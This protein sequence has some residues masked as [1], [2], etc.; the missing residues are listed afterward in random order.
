M[1]TLNFAQL[2]QLAANAG[3][4]SGLQNT[5]AAI[6]LAESGGN[7]Q[8]T[9]PNDNGGRQTSWGLWQISYGNHTPPPNWSNPQANA[10]LAYQKYLSQGLGA[11]GTYTS[12][13]YK[14][15]MN[16][17]TSSG[18]APWYTFPR[19]DN[20]GQIDPQ[21]NFWKPDSNIQLPGG[22]PIT[23]LLSGTVTSV[24]PTTNWGGQSVVTVKL[25]TPLNSLATHTFY[26]HMSG[27]APG[28]SVGQHVN[29]GDLIGYNN[30]SG[31]V[32]LGFGL[33]S[34]DVYGSG[35]AWQVLQQDLA[36]GGA[37]LLNPT[38][39]LNSA[40]QSGGTWSG[41]GV[42]S[43]N[44]SGL[45]T[46]TGC[47]WYDLPCWFQ[48]QVESLLISSGFVVFGLVLLLVG[49]IILFFGHGGGIEIAGTGVSSGGKG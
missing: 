43:Y 1:T 45:N 28:L 3:F 25:D 32:P 31:Q 29:A 41:S 17:S 46:S 38:N 39:L 24:Q 14:Q 26:E 7:P 48:N 5:M 18:Q 30:P 49:I 2:K 21:G 40:A 11:W 44:P 16:T 27:I 35:S 22:Y 10:N 4:P 13:K 37:G 20:F 15:Y 42:V 19:I 12:G 8:S 9:N 34:G 33:Y 23:A 6:A 47:Q 36:P